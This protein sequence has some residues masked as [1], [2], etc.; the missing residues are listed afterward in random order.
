M[1]K[2]L[3]ICVLTCLFAGCNSE[4]EH[5]VDDIVTLDS[6]LSTPIIIDY[7]T[8]ET[9][10]KDSDIVE[11][12]FVMPVGITAESFLAFINMN[13]EKNA[14]NGHLYSL[15]TVDISQTFMYDTDGNEIYLAKITPDFFWC[16]T[17]YIILAYDNKII[18]VVET[19]LG[20]NSNFFS[21]DVVKLSQGDYIAA[22]CAS[23]QGN[24][25]LT[26]FAISEQEPREYSIFPAV[27]DNYEH[28][29]M[30]A[31]EY[32]LSSDYDENIYASEVYLGG[33]LHA[34][35]HDVNDDGNTD[36]ILS[37]IQLIYEHISIDDFDERILRK[38]YYIK[39]VY[40]YDSVLND[41]IYDEMVSERILLP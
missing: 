33:K 26:L 24:G 16:T 7:V 40:V 13:H 8:E 9:I 4:A 17:L 21:Y 19:G 32:G 30:T 37:G 15:S 34:E 27:D 14:D 41:F 10:V 2:L 22:Y 31:I 3:V 18:D 1:K 39:N 38:S 11:T 29:Q 12:E 36:I 6:V 28:M 25:D 23:H 35:Y 5:I 20:G